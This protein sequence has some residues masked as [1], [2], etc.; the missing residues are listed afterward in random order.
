MGSLKTAV[1]DE[2]EHHDED[3][4]SSKGLVEAIA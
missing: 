4:S 1:K 3:G 2:Y